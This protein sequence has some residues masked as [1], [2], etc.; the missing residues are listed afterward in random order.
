MITSHARIK[1]QCFVCDNIRIIGGT[2]NY[3]VADTIFIYCPVCS[4]LLDCNVLETTH[5]AIEKKWE[6]I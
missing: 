3:I 6:S 1:T 5:K 4:K 2:S